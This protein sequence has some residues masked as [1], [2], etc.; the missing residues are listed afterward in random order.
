MTEGPEQRWLHVRT[1]N[2]ELFQQLL[3]VVA[4]YGGVG[5]VD[6][7]RV[8]EL[9]LRAHGVEIG[10]KTVDTYSLLAAGALQA[11]KTTVRPNGSPSSIPRHP[12]R[13]IKGGNS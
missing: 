12:L 9:Y 7:K 10:P 6:R 5:G 3:G 2:P 11:L 13:V 4:R 1:E 8:T